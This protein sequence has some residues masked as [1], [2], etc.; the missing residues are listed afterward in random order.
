MRFILQ[1][2][3]SGSV[4]KDSVHVLQTSQML[5]AV[6]EASVALRQACQNDW[7]LQ[8][9]ANEKVEL[10]QWLVQYLVKHSPSDHTGPFLAV[11]STLQMAHACVLKRLW[12]ETG[13][14]QCQGAVHVRILPSSICGHYQG[15]S[16]GSYRSKHVVLNRC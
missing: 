14:E 10:R 9:K 7:R 12:L 2:R 11:L 6:F 8:V 15:F 4:I 16:I 13:A 3:Q 1:F 5:E